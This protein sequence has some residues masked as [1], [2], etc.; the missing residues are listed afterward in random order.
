MRRRNVIR[1]SLGPLLFLGLVLYGLAWGETVITD[2]FDDGDHAQNPEWIVDSGTFE[3]KD[4]ELAFGTEPGTGIHLAI[5]DVAWRTPVEVSFRLRQADGTAASYMFMTGLWDSATEKGY[6]VSGSPNP[7]HFGTPSSGFCDGPLRSALGT[8]GARLNPNTSPQ[9]ITMRF[10]PAV[11]SVTLRQ[12]GKVVWQRPNYKKLPRVDRLTL[13]SEGTLSWFV[14]DVTVDAVLR[15]PSEV[16]PPGHEAVQTIYRGGVPHTDKRGRRM[17]EYE[18]ERSFF[19]IGVWGTP[20]GKAHGVDHDLKVL[21]EAGFNTIWPWYFPPED[22]LKAAQEAGL[23]VVQMGD[24]LLKDTDLLGK[25]KDHPNLLGNM[26]AEEP[27]GAWW[28][29]DMEARFE[30]FLAY[31]EK[32]NT[33]APDLPFFV[34][35]VPWIEPPATDWWIKWNTAGDVSCH[36]NYPIKHSAQTHSIEKVARVVAMAANVNEEKKPVWLTVG[37]FGDAPGEGSFRFPT[38][39]QLRACVYAGLIHGATGMVYFIWDSYISRNGGCVGMSPDPKVA[40]V[41]F[42]KE[43]GH[44][45]PSPATPMQLIA[46]RALWLAAV[47]INNEMRELAPVLL[48][49]TVSEEV[50]GYSVMTVELSRTE[51]PVR[52]LLKPHPAGG[53]VLMTVNLDDN[54]LGAEFTFSRGLRSV[55]RIFENQPPLELE[56]GVTS[57]EDSFEPFE[58]HVY[59]IALAD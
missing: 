3:V 43:P 33:I 30:A 39:M 34:L 55:E 24:A 31:K 20:V 19:Q 14:D 5:G 9:Q 32:V 6:E 54:V 13:A 17:M 49:P 38:P 7:G 47:Q 44:P 58:V 27:T 1:L 46:S 12:D 16:P 25:V 40:Y 15:D 4:G 26:W 48:S 36:D 50:L 41:P 59:R 22:S 10:D 23:Q 51:N 56:E 45:R 2:D 52:C 53:Y 18:P 21:V 28:G 29:K 42:P 8:A 11:N 35:D 57:F 37:A